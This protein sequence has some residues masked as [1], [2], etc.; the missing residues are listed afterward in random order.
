M[1]D[2]ITLSNASKPRQPA[3]RDAEHGKRVGGSGSLTWPKLS[4]E[5]AVEWCPR[6]S[7]NKWQGDTND[8]VA[9]ILGYYNGNRF[10][11]AQ[12]RSILDQSHKNLAV[13]ICDDHSET[14]VDLKTLNFAPDEREKIRLKVRSANIGCT[15]NFLHALREIGRNFPYFAFSDQDDIWHADK[16][17]DALEILREYPPDR[18]VL[19]CARTRIVDEHARIERGSSRL[20]AKPAAFANALVQNIASGNTMVF[21]K[22]ARDLIV[23]SCANVEVVY[24]DWWCYQIVSGAGGIVHYDP[25]P[26]LKYRQHGANLIGENQSSG[27][28][29]ERIQGLLRGK[30]RN[31]MDINSVA[32]FRNRRFLTMENRKCLDE[33]ITARKSGV[34]RRLLLSR[35][36]GI[37]RQTL[38]DNI[39][40][41]LGLLINRV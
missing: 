13:F 30:F 20:F 2:F 36:A 4:D 6:S 14:G 21:N 32:L 5:S 28:K 24:H 15:N 31:W 34:L 25:K 16:L 40:L 18:P 33:F 1:A 12:I 35:R 17:S 39:G 23:A 10:L 19:Y 38:L 27:S 3:L 8:A 9:V 29:L 22:A 11:S 7:S 26:C 37:Y 41:F